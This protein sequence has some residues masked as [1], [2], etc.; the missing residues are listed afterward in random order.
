MQQTWYSR[1]TISLLT[2][3]L[4][5]R[6][7]RERGNRRYTGTLEIFCAVREIGGDCRPDEGFPVVGLMSKWSTVGEVGREYFKNLSDLVLNG[8]P[9]DLASHAIE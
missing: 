6:F 4:V 1:Q 9:Y 7:W 8:R 3:R 2:Q 5:K